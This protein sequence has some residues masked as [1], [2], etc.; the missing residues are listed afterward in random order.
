MSITKTQINELRRQLQ[1]RQ[2]VLRAVVDE[3]VTHSER[4]S[5]EELVGRVRDSGDDAF[6]D[7][8]AD[9]N[10]ATLDR[11]LEEF[12]DIQEALQRISQGTFGEC[13]D[14]GAG[15]QVNRLKAYPTAKRCLRCQRHYEGTYAGK[16][17]S[18]I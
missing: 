2:N 14:C 5:Y 1:E 13:L 3:E 10:I 4:E 9:L 16:P 12:S 11:E 7:V 18:K 15:I 17:H 6:V 8:V